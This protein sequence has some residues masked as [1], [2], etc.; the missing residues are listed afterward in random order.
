MGS[1][2]VRGRVCAPCPEAPHPLRADIGSLFDQRLHEFVFPSPKNVYHY[3]SGGAP[4]D[5]PQVRVSRL[6]G[7][8]SAKRARA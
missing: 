5:I 1:A 6:G 2:A 3:N 4:R 8:A 7:T